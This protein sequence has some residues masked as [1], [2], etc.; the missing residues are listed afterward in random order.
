MIIP[1]QNTRLDICSKIWNT[2]DMIKTDTTDRTKTGTVGM[3]TDIAYKT[4]LTDT[5]DTIKTSR[6]FS[7]GDDAYSVHFVINLPEVNKIL[8]E[9]YNT[10]LPNEV[11]IEVI[12]KPIHFDLL[13]E[14]VANS[15]GDTSGRESLICA[16]I[17]HFELPPWPSM[18]ESKKEFEKEWIKSIEGVGGTYLI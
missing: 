4:K 5:T 18:T 17:D 14:I 11:I 1:C 3:I 7:F 8:R 2:T 12:T 16:L 15:V 10:V 6:L 13:G 9:Y